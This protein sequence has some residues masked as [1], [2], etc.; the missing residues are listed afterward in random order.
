[1]KEE[2]LKIAQECLTSEEVEKIVKDKFAKAL[3]GAIDDAFR[4]GDAKHAIENKIKEIMVPYIEDYDF[5]AYLPKLDTVLTE[6]VNSESCLADKK[7]LKNFKELITEPDQKEIKLT[8]LFKSWIEWCENEIDTDGIEICYDDGIS[9]CPVGC[10][11][12]YEEENKPSWSSIQR[13][14]I[15]FENEHDKKLNIEIPISKWVWDSGKEEPYTLNALGDMTISSL[16]RLDEFQLLLLRMG[17]AGTAV[18]IDKEH[19]DG[20]IQPEKEPQATFS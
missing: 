19:E 3:E 4:W 7:I 12:R 17:K 5:S 13:A 2:L 18:I 20:E 16:R 8:D 15:I 10:E 9:Y 11:M 1:M 14:V 6:L